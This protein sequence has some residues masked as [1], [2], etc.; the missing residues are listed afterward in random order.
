[1]DLVA[2]ILENH[3]QEQ[4]KFKP[5]TVEKHLELDYDL[6]TLLCVDKNELDSGL[7]SKNKEDYIQKL[8]R[9]NVQLLLN[10]IWGLPTEKIDDVVVA[11]LPK[12]TYILPRAR[13]VPKPKPLTKWQEYAK[14]KGIQKKK[15][16]KLSWD[17]QLQKW[18]PLY[19]Y[20]RAQVTRDKDWLLEVPQ[21]ADPLEDQ[22]AK[23]A[24]V[25]TE[26]VAKN[27]L[28]RL[29]NIAKSRNIKVP[30]M[31]LLNPDVSSAK[32]LQTAVTVAKSSTASIGKFQS[33]LPKEKEAKGVSAITPGSSSRKRKAAPVSSEE[34]K[35]ENLNAIDY[36]LNKKPKID[37]E[38]AVNRNI[39]QEQQRKSEET[40]V[41]RKPKASSKGKKKGSSSSSS[42]KPKSGR[43][44]RKSKSSGRKRR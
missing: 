9:D 3:T 29:R 43:G 1:M 17:E 22:F 7:L 16:S 15:K 21:N 40:T 44:Q 2:D 4:A 10:Q 38:K 27:E 32:D 12:P 36:V 41:S 28:Q 14:L 35:A 34:E 31:G 25:K 24:E 13:H 5:I 11:K 18:I 20:K 39:N 19:G 30:R 8:T 6:G 23:K 33:S 42:K 26:R 37:I